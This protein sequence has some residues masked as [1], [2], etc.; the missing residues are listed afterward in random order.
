MK[1]QSSWIFLE[2]PN[3]KER[4]SLTTEGNTH[5]DIGHS[6]YS[7]ISNTFPEVERVVDPSD[8]FSSQ[9]AGTL[10]NCNA[11]FDIHGV[12]SMQYLDVFVEGETE[13]LVIGCLEK[14]QTSLLQS[15]IKHYY[16]DINSY[17]AVSEYYCNLI[18]G[19]F[20]SFERNLRKLLFNTYVLYF[21][22]NYYQVTM[23]ENLQEKV[24]ELINI[25]NKAEIP[26]IRIDY[27]VDKEQAKAILYLKYFFY[28]LELKE[29]INFMFAD[30]RLSEAE[31]D[32]PDDM[33]IQVDLAKMSDCQISEAVANMS[34]KSDWD[35][36]FASKIHIENVKGKIERIR[37][38]RNTV[39][40]FKHFSKT[41][42]FE[43]LSL[44]REFN[45][46]FHKAIEETKTVDFANRNQA[47]VKDALEPLLRKWRSIEEPIRSI[48]EK[49][50]GNAIRDG[51]DRYKKSLELSDDKDNQ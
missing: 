7:F 3:K 16:V 48:M 23:D 2:H 9:L 19:D 49:H 34:S 14:I 31:S 12:G 29:A 4:E 39:A 50:L 17:D 11:M 45:T 42:Y 38:Y 24:R 6:L 18:V 10:Y 46:A 43:C 44:L 30:N 41:D 32:E 36:F 28:S 47:I 1:I 8:I 21:R 35:K 40:H 27:S 22:E 25:A 26:R 20:N 33:N 15:G 37:K 13:E 5:L 51:F